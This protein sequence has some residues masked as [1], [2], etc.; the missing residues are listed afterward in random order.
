MASEIYRSRSLGFYR[1]L[2]MTM[3]GGIKS[4]AEMDVLFLDP[5]TARGTWIDDW[6][7]ASVI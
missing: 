7:A 5:F 2:R 6:R 1:S 4:A 3:A